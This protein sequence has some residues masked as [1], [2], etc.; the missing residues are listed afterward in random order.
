MSTTKTLLSALICIALPLAPVRAQEAVP[1]YQCMGLRNVW[2]G[3]GAMPPPVTEYSAPSSDAPS[4]GIALSTLIVDN[5]PSIVDDRVRVIRPNGDAAWIDSSQV[6]P[7]HVVSNPAAVC[8]VIRLPNGT[9][10][11]TSH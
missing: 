9:F 1:S 7:W 5:P 11:T 3:Q 8:S 2:N 6:E 4:V 10:R